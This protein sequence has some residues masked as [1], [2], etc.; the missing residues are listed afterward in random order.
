MSDTPRRCSLVSSKVS[1]EPD[2]TSCHEHRKR[3]KKPVNVLQRL[4]NLLV[5]RGEVMDMLNESKEM[6]THPEDGKVNNSALQQQKKK[7]FFKKKSFNEAMPRE[8]A[9]I[10]EGFPQVWPYNRKVSLGNLQVQNS[11]ECIDKLSWSRRLE[12]QAFS[13]SV[14]VPQRFEL[15]LRQDRCCFTVVCYL[16]QLA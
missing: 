15:A 3:K 8:R 16:P 4:K 6:I 5:S 13:H 9:W 7:A 11:D 1:V 12:N 14:G 10:L 2:S